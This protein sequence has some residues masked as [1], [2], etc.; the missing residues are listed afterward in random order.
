MPPPAGVYQAPPTYFQH[1]YAPG[2][3]Y[4]APPT[5]SAGPSGYYCPP[6]QPPQTTPP[7]APPTRDTP[8]RSQTAPPIYRE[9][10]PNSNSHVITSLGE[11]H[12]VM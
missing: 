2:G 10:K 6:A 11:S 1:P 9:T 4:Q 8:T 3:P 7:Q 12:D 5:Y